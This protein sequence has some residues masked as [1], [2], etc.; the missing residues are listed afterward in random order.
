MAL[1]DVFHG[2]QLQTDLRSVC[3][4]PLTMIL[5]G[6]WNLDA[7]TFDFW[8]NY[9]MRITEVHNQVFALF[10]SSVTNTVDFQFFFEAVV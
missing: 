9:L 4:A 7:D 8:H 3:P 2:F 5:F 6:R 1:A 10:C